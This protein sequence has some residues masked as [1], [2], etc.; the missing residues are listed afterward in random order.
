M[1]PIQTPTSAAALAAPPRHI[2]HIVVDDMGWDDLGFRSGQIDTPN[3]DRLASEGVLL[4]QFYAMPVCSPSRSS[5]MTGRY[6][7]RFG[8]Q[9]QTNYWPSMK[10]GNVKHMHG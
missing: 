10:L 1:H 2:I 9:H 3:I 6:P 8:L 5:M 4:Q 7:M